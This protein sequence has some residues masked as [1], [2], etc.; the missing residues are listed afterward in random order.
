MITKELIHHWPNKE[1]KY[2]LEE[3]VPRFKYTLLQKGATNAEQVDIEYGEW[4]PLNLNWYE[5]KQL[6]MQTIDPPRHTYIIPKW[7]ESLILNTFINLPY[8]INFM[9]KW[10]HKWSTS[11]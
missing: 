1:I 9:S 11:L 6:V 5:R 7:P 2:F 4:R 10:A 3:V 8:L